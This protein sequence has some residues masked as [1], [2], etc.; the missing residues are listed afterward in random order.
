MNA[1][2]S[3]IVWQM[4]EYNNICILWIDDVHDMYIIKRIW[5]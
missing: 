5:I 3:D 4:H 2:I 1:G